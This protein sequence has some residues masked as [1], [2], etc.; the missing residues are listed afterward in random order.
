MPA[1]A[2]R[3]I[4]PLPPRSLSLYT[5][6]TPLPHSTFSLDDQ[7]DD[8]HASSARALRHP[9]LHIPPL[10]QEDYRQSCGR[11]QEVVGYCQQ[12]FMEEHLM[13]MDSH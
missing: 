8:E 10:R 5:H 3:D 7:A 2:C 1:P 12:R 11:V 6:F 13:S 4:V 9:H